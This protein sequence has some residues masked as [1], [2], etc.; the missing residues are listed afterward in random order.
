M[1]GRRR[2]RSGPDQQPRAAGS[3]GRQQL[4]LPHAIRATLQLCLRN[5]A[6]LVSPG[7]Y[8]FVTGVDLDVRT[9]V[10]LELGWEPIP[11]LRA[12]IHDGDPLCPVRLAVAVVGPRA[13]RPA[14]ARLG[15]AL[16]RRLPD[17][18]PPTAHEQLPS[19]RSGN[20]SGLIRSCES[21][22]AA[23]RL[24]MLLFAHFHQQLER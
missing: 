18:H 12:E 6:Q 21:A 9:Q 5:L 8:L 14:A 22:S 19:A 15:D 20:R 2:L 13:A 24:P 10:A 16:Q 3:G 23:G 4:P 17:Q 11:E 7:G 1:A